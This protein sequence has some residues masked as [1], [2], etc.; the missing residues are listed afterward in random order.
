ML[1]TGQCSHV[2]PGNVSSVLMDDS[3]VQVLLHFS[4][5]LGK[6]KLYCCIYLLCKGLMH[7]MNIQYLH[8]TLC[9]FFH[10]L[11]IN[12]LCVCISTP[13]QTPAHHLTGWNIYETAF[14]LRGFSFFSEQKHIFTLYSYFQCLGNTFFVFPLVL[15]AFFC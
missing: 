8:L 4:L 14:L 12:N 5:H 3:A 6:P 13:L 10:F 9:P 7:E 15:N 1:T 2:Q 11:S